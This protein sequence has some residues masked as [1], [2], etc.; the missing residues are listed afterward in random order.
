MLG[1]G[2]ESF[3]DNLSWYK[4][5]QQENYAVYDRLA[6][7]AALAVAM[8]FPCFQAFSAEIT[9]ERS[10]RGAV[11]KIDGRLFTEYLIRSGTKPILWPIIGPT[12]QRMTR[13]YPMLDRPGE[14]K[15]HP[16]QRSI[17]FT[18]GNVSGVN[19]WSES[20]RVGTIK[21]LEFTKLAGGRPAT[22]A[23]RDAWLDPDGKKLLEDSR[24]L[25]F[26][27]DGDAR[28]IDFD[29]TL[30]ATDGKVTFGDTKEGSFG[31]RVADTM[32]VERGLG[33]EIVNSLHQRNKAAWG[34]RAAWVDYHGPVDGQTVGI[35]V[36]NHPGSFRFPTCWHVRPYG[37]LAANP[38]GLREFIGKD[39]DGAKT[40]AA[41]EELDPAL[42]RPA[43][44]RRRASGARG[45]GLLRLHRS[46]KIGEKLRRV[47]QALARSHQD[48]RKTWWD[49]AK[50][51][52]TLRST[53]ASK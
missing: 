37:L 7:L 39:S 47:G 26:D 53:T 48:R 6:P 22:I 46:I 16:H 18:H 30:K 11:V 4:H 23:A 50:A 45:Q 33:G 32:R 36:L 15:D 1:H 42:P 31:I 25:H 20:G 21:H 49:C 27:T 3:S 9:V 38:F 17:F 2:C 19:F 43:A 52:P 12:G 24:T 40:L 51:C 35:A 34:K 8:F 29:I 28:W 44:P 13:D 41:G 14:N 10:E 5:P